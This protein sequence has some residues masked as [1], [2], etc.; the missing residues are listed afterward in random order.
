V[1]HEAFI[2][3]PFQWSK[4]A[5]KKKYIKKNRMEAYE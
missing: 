1:K 4:Y 2:R 3:K 5:G